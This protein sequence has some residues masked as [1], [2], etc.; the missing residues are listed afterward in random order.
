MKRY[1][2]VS[3]LGW[4]TLLSAVKLAAHFFVSNGSCGGYMAEKIQS[5]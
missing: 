2:S 4:V 1:R 3:V 5:Y